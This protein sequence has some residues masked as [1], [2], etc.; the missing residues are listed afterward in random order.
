LICVGVFLVLVFITELN[1]PH[2]F[3]WKPTYDKHDKDPFG[4]YVFDD[5][6]SSSLSFYKVIRKTFYQLY[7]AD[8]LLVNEKNTDTHYAYLIIEDNI[9]LSATDLNYLF[10]LL[11]NGA[12]II[13]C[14]DNFPYRL[15]DTLKITSINSERYY[16]LD[17]YIQDNGARD[18]I[19]IYSDNKETTYIYEVYPHLHNMYLSIE[20]DDYGQAKQV[21]FKPQ[22][23]A[24][25]K[26]KRPL[27]VKMKIGN[28]HL[29]L[30]SV[31]LMFTNFS[32]LDGKNA[33]FTFRLL[34]RLTDKKIIRLEAYGKHVDEPVTPLR[35]VLT[36]TPLKW[37]IYLTFITVLLFLFFTARRRQRI[38]PVCTPP[39]NNTLAFMRLISNLYFQQHDNGEIIKIKYYCFCSY[40]KK[41]TFIDIT[42]RT[43]EDIDYNRISLISG[44]DT[45][46]IQ[47]LIKNIH[48]AIYRS[49]A[50][51]LQLKQYCNGLNDIIYSLKK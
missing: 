45:T 41:Y 6:A 10:K 46:I 28:G 22:T 27:A 51:D 24:T 43:P 25:D 8:S 49:H 1:A 34:N 31:P 42:N 7:D 13:L 39:S 18:S 4:C 17:R 44:I 48:M 47:K 16:S 37:A 30:V 50:D 36:V 40:L 26:A 19:M 12:D 33:D 14:T 15:E 2:K 29:A 21:P 32:I 5:V 38:I 3:S 35:Y 11:D 20:K 23:I 9:S